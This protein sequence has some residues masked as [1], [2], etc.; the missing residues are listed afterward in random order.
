MN[1]KPAS[2]DAPGQAH[3]RKVHYID[4]VLQKRLLIALVALETTVLSL[5]GAILY[6]RLN[7]IVDE[8]L[9]RIHFASQPS[10]FSVL[11]KESLLIL[12]GLVAV[13]L[14]ALFAAD[15][16]WSHYVRSILLSL[17]SLLSR[18]RDLDLRA[19]PDLPQRHKVLTL[20]IDW[21]RT[22]R[23]R[24]LALYESLHI[25]ENIAARPAASAAEIRDGLLNFRKH[26]PGAKP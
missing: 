7:T 18:T 14:V 3:Q 1:T 10:M 9:Y 15:R 20:A 19:D 24:H 13:N 2:A 11:L 12:G 22:E 6:F 5:A 4:H 8:S 25:V 17:R 21:R 26:L 23:A 16:I